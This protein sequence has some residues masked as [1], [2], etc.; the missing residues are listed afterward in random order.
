M[1]IFL[2]QLLGLYFLV[3]GTLVLVRRKSIMPAISE[4]VQNRALLFTIA[5]IELVAG[6]SIVLL[7][8]TLSW[9]WLGLI[10]LIGWMMIVEGVVHLSL[11]F[12]YVQQLVRSFNKPGWYLSGGMVAVAIGL[13]LVAAGFGFL[14]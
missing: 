12:K 3:V 5:S 13:Y 8:P 7:Y 2:A 14:V 1:D 6:L 9:T 4:L 10:S 11:P